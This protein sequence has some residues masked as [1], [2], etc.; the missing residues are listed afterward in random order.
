[1]RHRLCAEFDNCMQPLADEAFISCQRHLVA[2]EKAL[3]HLQEAHAEL[4]NDSYEECVAASIQR[5]LDDI[6]EIIGKVTADDVLGEI[7][8][9][10]C[11]GK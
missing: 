5:A 2:L 9:K 11:I 6:E 10:F 4:V 8:A 3:L 1:M 7:F